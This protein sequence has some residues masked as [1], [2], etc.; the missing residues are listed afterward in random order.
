MTSRLSMWDKLPPQPRE[1]S[2]FAAWLNSSRA[3]VS[4]SGTEQH[5]FAMKVGGLAFSVLSLSQKTQNMQVPPFI[6]VAFSYN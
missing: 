5:E 1:A 3:S 2:R 6:K 4:I